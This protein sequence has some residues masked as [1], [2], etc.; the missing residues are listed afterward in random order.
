MVDRLDINREGTCVAPED[1]PDAASRAKA[2]FGREILP[3][4]ADL[5]QYLEHNWRNASDITDLRQEI[6]AR[7]F[8]AAMEKIPDR[9]KQYLFVTA[10][11]LLINRMRHEQ[12]VPIEAAADLDMLDVIADEPGPDRVLM[13]RDELRR[14]RAALDR[15]APRCREA[16]TY[17]RI[18]GLSRP[19]IAARM[20]ISEIAV[21]QYLTQGIR[22]LADILYGEPPNVRRKP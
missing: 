14:L 15:L 19:E 1:V 13:A 21:S 11:N 17:G 9:P 3:L 12:V 5:M 7:V 22:A 4:E 18:D 6:Y 2:W 10:K 20:G 16:V 8:A